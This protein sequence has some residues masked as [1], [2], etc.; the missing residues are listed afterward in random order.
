M[1]WL[2]IENWMLISWVVRVTFGAGG[3]YSAPV[4]LS[5]RSAGCEPLNQVGIGDVRASE[6]DQ[7]HK[8]LGD[9]ATASFG[10]HTDAGDQLAAK[11]GSEMAEHA[12]AHQWRERGAGEVGG[13]A[14]EQEMRQT[15]AVEF[16]H[17]ILCDRQRLVIGGHGAA[18]MHRADL[19]ADSRWIDLFEH[20]F[21][22]FEQDTSPV[23]DRTP[24]F[25]R[26]TIGGPVQ[27]LRDQVEI[28]GEYLQSVESGLHC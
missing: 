16:A 4:D 18:L 2:A 13:V 17:G 9:Q 11:D 14:H 21:H 19:H 12:V 6:R 28:G 1:C 25:I 8:P 10:G 27:E 5:E 26:A 3:V 22:D 15:V 7:V 20:R 23:F 24:I